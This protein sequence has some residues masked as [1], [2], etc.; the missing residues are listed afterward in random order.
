M[1]YEG[2]W[3]Y[4]ETFNNKSTGVIKV[5]YYAR[6]WLQGKLEC[7]NKEQV[8]QYFKE[9]PIQSDRSIFFKYI[10]RKASESWQYIAAKEVDEQLEIIEMLKQSYKNYRANQNVFR[11][12][13]CAYYLREDKTN[14]K[15]KILDMLKEVLD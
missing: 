7:P 6:Y 4:V 9:N 14:F 5:I 2:E 1:I 15:I 8:V 12:G 3:A 10:T 11:I 13:E